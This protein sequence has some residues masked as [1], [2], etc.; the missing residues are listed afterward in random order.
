[1]VLCVPLAYLT[2][3]FPAGDHFSASPVK[4]ELKH[5]AI[6]RGIADRV[7]FLGSVRH[8]ELPGLYQRATL[9]VY[10]FVTAS[11][12]DEEGFGLVVSEA[13]WKGTPVVAG[14]ADEEHSPEGAGGH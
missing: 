7:T 3:D 2:I 8:S 12:G 10:P 13:L 11:D 1:M 14:H 6:A 5:Q 9:A 4:G